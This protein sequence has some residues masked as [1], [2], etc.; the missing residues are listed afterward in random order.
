MDTHPYGY[1]SFVT[2]KEGYKDIAKEVE[3]YL[4]ND[5]S[6]LNGF[7]VDLLKK[8][9]YKE[10][11][12]LM[13]SSGP[14]YDIMDIVRMQPTENFSEFSLLNDRIE[15]FMLLDIHA[16][17]GLS[18]D[19]FLLLPRDKVELVFRIAAHK[20]KNDYKTSA[21]INNKLQNELGKQ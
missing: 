3:T 2:F 18:V 16:L 13:D 15:K 17:T 14:N 1:G 8:G 5:N 20:A 10:I 9:M 4:R 19:D 6:N 7:T 21:D 12:G 11:F